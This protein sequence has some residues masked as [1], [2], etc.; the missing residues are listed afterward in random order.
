MS[1][2]SVSITAG[3]TMPRKVIKKKTT[4]TEEII[5]TTPE[6]V[7]AM[8]LDESGSMY[9]QLQ[10]TLGAVNG[11]LAKLKED[12]NTRSLRLYLRTFSSARQQRLVEGQRINDMLFQGLTVGNYT[13]M[14]GTPLYDSVGT[15][16]EEL[17]AQGHEKVLFTIVTDGQENSSKK[18]SREHIKDKIAATGWE[19]NFLGANFDAYGEA[20]SIGIAPQHT[21]NYTM[22]NMTATM[23]CAFESTSRYVASKGLVGS[24]AYTLTEKRSMGDKS[25]K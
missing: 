23:D 20:Q 10:D 14:G 22:D 24:S 16:I 17:R 6:I 4:V 2:T 15:F 1:R 19:F 13:P 9:S 8:L 21:V 11:Y 18:Y 12:D 3:E 5:E 7:V 25:G